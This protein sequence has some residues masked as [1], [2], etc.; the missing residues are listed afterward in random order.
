MIRAAII[1]V[2]ALTWAPFMAGH[3]NN[4][5]PPTPP[6]TQGWFDLGPGGGGYVSGIVIA[7]DGT[8]VAR[9]D[10]NAGAWWWNSSLSRWIPINNSVSNPDYNNSTPTYGGLIGINIAPSNTSEFGMLFFNFPYVTLNKGQSWTKVANFPSSNYDANLVPN[11]WIEPQITFDPNNANIFY[12]TAYTNGVYAC[13]NSSTWDLAT[14]AHVLTQSD[15]NG[16]IF[17]YDT[18]NSGCTSPVASVSQCINI[19]AVNTGWFRSTNG[20]TSFT[21]IS[22]SGT[23]GPGGAYTGSMDQDGVLW[24]CDIASFPNGH[25]WTFTINGGTIPSTGLTC[26]TSPG[27]WTSLDSVAGSGTTTCCQSV[28]VD[29]ANDQHVIMCANGGGCQTSINRGAHWVVPA[30]PGAVTS[31]DVTWQLTNTSQIGGGLN[32]GGITFDPSQSGVLYESFGWGIIFGRP[33]TNQNLFTWTAQSAGTE[34]TIGQDIRA[35]S[36]GKIWGAV[37]DIGVFPMAT[38]GFPST[39]GPVYNG[40]APNPIGLLGMQSVDVATDNASVIC[41]TS[42]GFQVTH[43]GCSAD[44]GST[45]SN[46]SNWNTHIGGQ[47]RLVD[48]TDLI[49]ANKNT[50]LVYGT[51]LTSNTPTLNNAVNSTDGS[52]NYNDVI[53]PGD[54]CHNISVADSQGAVW[55]FQPNSGSPHHSGIWKSTDKGHTWTYVGSAA[56][57]SPGHT[58]ASSFLVSISGTNPTVLFYTNGWFCCGGQPDLATFLWV[59]NSGNSYGFT[60]DTNWK[61]VTAMASGPPC[62][63]HSVGALYVVGWYGGSADTNYGVWQSCNPDQGTSATYTQLGGIGNC[64]VS[65]SGVNQLCNIPLGNRSIIDA[66]DADQTTPGLVY[67]MFAGGGAAYYHP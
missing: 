25:C 55:A 66:I 33:F 61:A 22:S 67:V 14:C 38:S 52:I 26:S 4:S 9:S 63:G 37:D 53:C 42:V 54:N 64:T 30:T 59:S 60:K 58:G 6:A 32:L 29:P 39:Y 36:N 44:G 20:G 27:C 15:G 24:T 13:T 49:L 11:K 28:R 41:A 34:N 8:R 35:G 7:A 40:A 16:H 23:V 21:Q 10:A 47:W 19:G 1:F 12:A 5:A 51:N 56:D 3:P 18:V 2:L 48:S 45:W 50:G 17:V 65:S 57:P 62:V 31:A 46:F 43:N